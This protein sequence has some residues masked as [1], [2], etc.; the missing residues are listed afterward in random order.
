MVSQPLLIV[1]FYLCTAQCK[2]LMHISI[3]TL[4]IGFKPVLHIY[5]T[6]NSVIVNLLLIL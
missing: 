6:V 5:I 2:S 3:F 1:V 4:K